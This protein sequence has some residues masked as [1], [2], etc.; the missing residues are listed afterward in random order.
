MPEIKK[1]FTAGRMKHDLDERLIPKEEYL[2]ALNLD[3]SVSTSEN[4]G[5]LQNSYGNTVQ[6]IVSDYIG[7]AT[8]I[9]S[10]VDNENDKIYWFVKG[11]EEELVK[12]GM[13][14]TIT[15]GNLVTDGTFSSGVSEWSITPGDVGTITAT[16]GGRLKLV[17]GGVTWVGAAYSFPTTVGKVYQV[18]FTIEADG[19]NSNDKT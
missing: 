6:S 12:N 1:R 13:F 8:C 19:T 9:G 3:I 16:S 7:D 17:G 18:T 14:N 10:V 11:V 5:A 4:D 15:G 2:S